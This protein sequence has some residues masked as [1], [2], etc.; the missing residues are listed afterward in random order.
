M[1]SIYDIVDGVATFTGSTLSAGLVIYTLIL[2]TILVFLKESKG[3]IFFIA[4][5]VTVICGLLNILRT[6]V[7]TLILIVDIIGCA[8][9][10]KNIIKE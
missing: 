5:P 3:K 6:D 10:V 4:L 7:M 8:Y 9:Q 2:L 1:P